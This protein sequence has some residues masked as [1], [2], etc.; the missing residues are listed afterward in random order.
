MEK[1]TEKNIVRIAVTGP[2]STGKSVLAEKLAEHFK[3]VWVPEYAREYLSRIE[4]PY[5]QDDILKIAKAQVESEK[6][7]QKDANNIIFSDTELIVTKIWSEVKYGN[8]DKWIID[9]IDCQKYDLYLLCDIDLPWEFDV[10]REHPEQRD[11]LMKLYENELNV[12]KM[13]YVKISGSGAQRVKNAIYFVE[14]LL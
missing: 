12:R 5:D 6:Q 2:E 9:N 3:T 13:N 4:R 11:L 10:L 7:L 1:R 14:N 8:C